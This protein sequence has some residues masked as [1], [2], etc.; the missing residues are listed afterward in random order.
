MYIK[1]RIDDINFPKQGKAIWGSD[2]YDVGAYESIKRGLM[3]TVRLALSDRVYCLRV[4]TTGNGEIS[5]KTIAQ[6]RANIVGDFGMNIIV[7]TDQSQAIPI[8]HL[9]ENKHS[10]RGYA[11]GEI[12]SPVSR[13]QFPMTTLL[14]VSTS[15]RTL[16]IGLLIE[17][18]QRK[19]AVLLHLLENSSTY[20]PH[21]L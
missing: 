18:L 20:Y 3:K 6:Q 7:G 1:V 9:N 17:V 21:S 10:F 2:D 15:I 14:S 16:A 5:E 13:G 8:R 12:V 19:T 11:F 4:L